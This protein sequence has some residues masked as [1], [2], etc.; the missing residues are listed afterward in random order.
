MMRF[1]SF[2]FT[3]A[4][5]FTTGVA[6]CQKSDRNDEKAIVTKIDSISYSLGVLIGNNNFKQIK[7]TAGFDKLNKEIIIEAFKKSFMGDTVLINDKTSKA[8]I[9][10][11]FAEVS[12][13]QQKQTEVKKVE[14]SKQP[15]MEIDNKKVFPIVISN[16]MDNMKV[17]CTR[18]K[19]ELYESNS[20]VLSW[21]TQQETTW[22]IKLNGQDLL[23]LPKLQRIN[24]EGY[25]VNLKIPK[26]YLSQELTLFFTNNNGDFS[27]I[28]F[29]VINLEVNT[30]NGAMF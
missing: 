3:S 2:I 10:A 22:S 5:I 28:K 7:E 1:R 9:R 20:I 21:K 29:T 16:G 4:F 8:I 23:G 12:K 15:V 30:N 6:L 14:E 11:F 27:S 24:S 19:N 25:W 17:E 13:I 18:S 26:Q